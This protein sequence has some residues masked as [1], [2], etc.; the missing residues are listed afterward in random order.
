[1]HAGGEGNICHN[2]AWEVVLA[3]LQSDAD[4]GLDEAE[5]AARL[6][7]HGENVLPSPP[8]QGLLRRFLAQLNNPLIYVLWLAALVTLFLGHVTDTGVIVGVILINALLGV[9]QEGRA[10]R[11]LE[12]LRQ[13]LTPYAQVLRNGRVMQIDASRL[14]PGDIVL[15]Q[16]GDKVPA[17]MRLIRVHSLAIDESL[18]TGESVPAEKG[19]V[20]VAVGARVAERSS[21]GFAGTLVTQ[22]QGMGVVVAT[23]VHTELGR[24]SALLKTVP[25]LTTPLLRH[26]ERLSRD[27]SLII[28][29]LALLAFVIGVAWQG[30]PWA[31]TFLIAVGM[32]VAAIPEGL[33]AVLTIALAIGVQRMARRNAIVRRLPAVE[34]LGAVTTICTDKTGTLTCNVL[35]AVHVLTPQGE[36]TV[37]GAGYDPH[38][39]VLRDGVPIERDGHP[40]VEALLHAAML[41]N[42]AELV[43]DGDRRWHV[44]GDPLEGALLVLARKFGLDPEL[45]RARWPRLEL[46]P[47]D[48]RLRYMVTLHRDPEEGR[49]AFIKGAP[50][51]ILARL[52]EVPPGIEA[53]LDRLAGEGLRLIAFARKPLAGHELVAEDLSGGLEWQGVVGFI[54]P[55]R[56]GVPEAVAACQQAG[57]RVKMITGDHAVTA[58]AIAR[59][60]GIGDGQAVLTGEELERLAPNELAQRVREADVFA[61]T[62][63]EQKLT[64]LSALQQA[65]EVVAMTGDGVNDAP[66]LKGAQVG[67][68]MGKTGSEVAREASV[69]VLADDNFATIAKA[70]R[71]GRGVYDNLR[72]TI[73]YILPSDAGEAMIML[74]ALLLGGVAPITPVQILWI[75]MVTTVNLALALAFERPEA[76]VMR[77]PPRS[78][79]ALLVGGGVL[80]RI[81]L[82][83]S[84]M[85]LG[86]YGMFNLLLDQGGSL[87]AARTAALNTIVLIECFYLLNARYLNAPVLNREG[88][89]GNP[90][91]WYVIGPLILLQLLV[92]YAPF[93]HALLGTAPLPA[94]TWGWMMLVAIGVML[95]VELEVRGRRW[96]ERR[97]A[98]PRGA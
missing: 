49:V 63:P 25:Q 29:A 93:M 79:R 87:E 3:T 53:E 73:L 94:V 7:R 35:T 88:L 21:M 66:A 13:V 60:L 26:L 83:G 12:A 96:W 28:L 70:V 56:E 80:W 17:D 68:A 6:A 71:E 97:A 33:P 46:L 61:R 18:L 2:L 64:L 52:K 67:I 74:A 76:D 90:V 14:V 95:V 39:R 42:D 57:I 15:L 58:A 22:G 54:D 19:T 38:G 55:P 36:Y 92:T 8:R 91:I 48:A 84:L 24:I 50:E 78:P 9:V 65:G 45:E 59:Q 16:A 82:V 62:T 85:V 81:V 89:F 41:C 27:L 98:S 51:V 10:E 69:I 43:R 5:A 11:A 1:M 31:D 47:F 37:E 32:A 20:P 75:N 77:R 72:K 4:H 30:L 23:G 40:D 86:G 44:L 34:A